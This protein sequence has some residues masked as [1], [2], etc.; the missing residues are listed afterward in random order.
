VDVAFVVAAATRCDE[1]AA[2]HAGRRPR[3]SAQT[4]GHARRSCPRRSCPRAEP[5]SHEGHEAEGKE[6]LRP[7]GR[8]LVGGVCSF[9]VCSEFNRQDAKATKQRERRGF[10]SQG[11]CSSGACAR[12]GRVTAKT[13]RSQGRQGRQGRQGAANGQVDRWK[14]PTCRLSAAWDCF[15]KTISPWFLSSRDGFQLPDQPFLY[16][17]FPAGDFGLRRFRY[18]SPS[19]TRS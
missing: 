1:P 10:A 3:R 12:S 15:L 8:V 4:G 18:D 6:G 7:S 19:M 9:G 13:P 14:G 2:S 5:R 16:P 17:G 11:G